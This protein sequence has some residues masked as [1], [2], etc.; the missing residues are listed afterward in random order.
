[1]FGNQILFHDVVGAHATALNGMGGCS[2][3]T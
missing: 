1:M 2:A 3:I